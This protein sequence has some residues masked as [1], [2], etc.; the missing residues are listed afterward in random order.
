M[1][2][3]SYD[4]V[5]CRL[6][7]DLGLRMMRGTPCRLVL[8]GEDGP[9]TLQ[10]TIEDLYTEGDAEYVRGEEGRTIRLDRIVDVKDLERD[11]RS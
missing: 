11:E 6:Y 8:E 4:P 7:D 9:E 5:A 3:S 10:T 2:D 1:S